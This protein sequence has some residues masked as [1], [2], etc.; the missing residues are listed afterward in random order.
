MKKNI[1]FIIESSETGGAESV[2]AELVGR[3]DRERYVPHVALL[4]DGWLLDRL[5]AGGI[6]PHLIPNRRGGFDVQMLRGIG[7]LIRQ[8]RI[9]LVH[10]HLFTTNLYSSVCGALTG[11]PV[12]ST[13]HGTM[14]VAANDRF[15][16]LK[17]QMINGLSRK[18]VFV[19]RSLQAYFVGQK[20]ANSTRSQVIYNGIDIDRFR[21]GPDKAAARRALNLSFDSFVV[22]CVGDLRQAKD[23]QSALRAISLLKQEIPELKLVIVGSK[24]GLHRELESLSAS[25]GLGDDVQFLG[26][27]PDVEN[28]LPAFDVYLS[29]SVSEGFSL[30]VVEAMATGLPVVATRSGGPEEIIQHGENGLL[31]DVGAPEKIA[32][33][34]EMLYRDRKTAALFSQ[35]GMRRAAANFSIQA[36]VDSYQALYGKFCQGKR[37]TGHA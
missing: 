8:K 34:V 20:L 37:Q 29:S 27:R 25:L 22:G 32:A 24:V 19:S 2:F 4:Y 30:T 10:S 16:R 36:M 11:V 7:K 28:V 17:W 3:I 1:L 6:A 35:A 15:K 33:A 23:Y 14:D 13:F 12:I 31:V 9:D 18:V 5:R 26:F 21:R